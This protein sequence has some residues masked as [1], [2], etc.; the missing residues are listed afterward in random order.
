MKQIFAK[1]SLTLI[2]I[3][4]SCY[5]SFGQRGDGK[6]LQKV[7]IIR[8]GEKPEEGDNLS[9]Q[10]FNRAFQ[11]ADV[12]YAKFKIPDYIFVPS[13]KTGKS[14]GTAR[15]YQTIIPFA[16]KQNLNINTK[17]EVNDVPGLAASI[18]KKNGTVLIVWEHN[19]ILK[20]VQALSIKD[21][22]L[23]WK[24]DDFDSIWIITFKNGNAVLS[25]DKE[26]IN[27]STACK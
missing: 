1:Q 16:V 6:S 14:T 3:L 21:N 18:L 10:G 2:L 8:H 4:L 27:P 22:H 25:Y 9:C 5:I 7:I 17:Y 24:G 26:N 12:L 15:M 23:K 13:I 19:Y 20:I 11:L